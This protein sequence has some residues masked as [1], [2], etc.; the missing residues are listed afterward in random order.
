MSTPSLFTVGHSN[1]EMADFL[2][3]LDRH[4]VTVV[5]DVRSNPYSRW[6]QFGRENLAGSLKDHGLRY[7]FLGDQ[8]G[9]RRPEVECYV[10]GQAVYELV[11]KL[12][13]FLEGV[14]RLGRGARDHVIAL[15]CAE[16]EPLD[17]H[18]GVLIARQLAER[19]WRVRHILADGSAE[20]HAATERRMIDAMGVDPLLD[21]N[22]TQAELLHRA[23][24]ELGGRLAYRPR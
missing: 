1:H 20:E 5:G 12:P 15:M 14:A 22:A 21:A 9:A 7:V 3:L 4:G 11:A 8:L 13:A 2:A 18:R 6:T 10:D 23:Y 16:R 17:C 24:E 19:G